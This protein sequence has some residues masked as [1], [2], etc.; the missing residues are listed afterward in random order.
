M[1]IKREIRLGVAAVLAFGL[2][3]ACNTK[4]SD[5]SNVAAYGGA[6]ARAADDNQLTIA[7]QLDGY[8]ISHV[9]SDGQGS[10]IQL[11]TPLDYGQTT[12]IA[13]PRTGNVE[14]AL[15]QKEGGTRVPEVDSE[16]S[17]KKYIVSVNVLR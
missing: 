6:N 4:S 7:N 8:V 9:R 10:G 16:L 1:S 11:Q 3:T 13:Y 12:K 14:L 17:A 2:A 5:S 15:Q